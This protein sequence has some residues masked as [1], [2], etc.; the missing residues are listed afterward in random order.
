M[1]LPVGERPRRRHVKLEKKLNSA[2]QAANKVE[3]VA[4][5][6]AATPPLGSESNGDCYRLRHGARATSQILS[7]A[8]TKTASRTAQK[9]GSA[10]LLPDQAFFA[11]AF[12]RKCYCEKVSKRVNAKASEKKKQKTNRKLFFFFLCRSRKCSTT[13]QNEICN[14]WL[15]TASLEQT[16]RDT[17]RW[18]SFF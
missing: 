7:P 14:R 4:V 1:L 9:F 18:A 17:K 3:R 5:S 15:T 11:V 8:L 2:R 16:F 13:N 6:E 12:E 10:R